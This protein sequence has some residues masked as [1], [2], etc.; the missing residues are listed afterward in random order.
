MANVYDVLK[1]RGF[2]KQTIYDEDL[3]K[4]LQE[5]KIS[6]SSLP[7]HFGRDLVSYKNDGLPVEILEKMQ[8]GVSIYDLIERAQTSENILGQG[9]NSI[10]YKIPQLDDFVSTFDLV[11]NPYRYRIAGGVSNVLNTL[12]PEEANFNAKRTLLFNAIARKLADEKG[13]LSDQDIK[14]IDDALP[15]LAD[16]KKQKMAKMGATYSLLDIRRGYKTPQA[17]VGNTTK[18]GVKYEVID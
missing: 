5:E 4:M 16:T 3:Y 2:I 6:F 8:K 15:K 11:D 18:S 13:V 17:Q 10:V 1:E 14:R 9:A 7:V 12:T